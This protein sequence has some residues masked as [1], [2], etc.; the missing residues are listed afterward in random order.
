MRPFCLSFA[1]AA[2]VLLGAPSVVWAIAGFTPVAAEG[3]RVEAN[4][5]W[6]A[7]MIDVVND[8]ARTVGWNF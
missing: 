7:K 4:L 2:A 1:V 5:Q 6:P 3:Q 8:P